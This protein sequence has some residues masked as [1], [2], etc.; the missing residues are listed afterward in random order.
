MAT[1]KQTIS[2]SITTINMKTNNFVEQNKSKTYISTL[3]EEITKLKIT[4]GDKLYANWKA[5]ITDLQEV[6]QY[7]EAIKEKEQI[8]EEQ[9]E[10]IREIEIQE[11]QI[12]GEDTSAN[13]AKQATVFCSM[14]GEQN[15]AEYK[16][17]VKCG[18]EL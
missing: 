13:N 11:R 16:F 4:I 17:C 2:K 18:K 5:G 9:K 7:L 8:I 12:L 6:E 3:E 15:N 14:C 1:L 10:R